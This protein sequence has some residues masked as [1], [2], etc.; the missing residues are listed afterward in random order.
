MA[1]APS[2]TGDAL[3]PRCLILPHEFLVAS[4]P[5]GSNTARQWPDPWPWRGMA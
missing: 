4:G 1:M 5:E 3:A 2:Q